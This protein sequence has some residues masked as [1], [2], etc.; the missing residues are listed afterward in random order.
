MIKG[1]FRDRVF[2]KFYTTI[3]SLNK[4]II[5]SPINTN[6]KLLIKLKFNNYKFLKK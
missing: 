4:N 1:L 3:N 6:T 5:I 2:S